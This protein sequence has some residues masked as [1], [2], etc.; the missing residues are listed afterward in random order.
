[1]DVFAEEKYQGNQLLVFRQAGHL[2]QAEM[3]KMAKEINF[4]ETTFIMSDEKNNGGYDV[5]IFTPDTEIPFAGHP[6]LGTAFILQKEVEKTAVDKILLN[7]GVGQIPVTFTK[8]QEL[9]MRQN[10]P[11]FGPVIDR[12]VMA[13]I[14]NL[15]PEDFD[16]S[17]PITAVSTGLPFII[18]PLKSLETVK[19]C[20]I[21]HPGFK[22]FIRQNFSA[23][24][25]V[26]C[27]ETYR[28]GNDLNVRVFCDDSGFPEDPATGSGNGCLAAYLLKYNY[29]GKSRIEY[30]VEQGYEI[31]RPSLLKIRAQLAA[32]E[33]EINV[34]GKVFLVAQGTWD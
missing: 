6:S 21:N 26:F 2:T 10:Q 31:G 24:I 15:D 29:L 28:E 4:S 5:K 8:T 23:N 19:K 30:Q 34:G 32:G 13:E 33:Y 27:R 11:V 22:S 18:V 9:W 12:Q 7:L 16:P 3:Q 25:L 20:L 1:V 14:L 17:Y